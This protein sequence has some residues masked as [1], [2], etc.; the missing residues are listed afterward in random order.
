MFSLWPV[1]SWAVEIKGLIWT[2]SLQTFICYHIAA[3]SVDISLP[4]ALFFLQKPS[5][6]TQDT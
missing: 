3:V 5:G 1:V 6:Q 2:I 4:T